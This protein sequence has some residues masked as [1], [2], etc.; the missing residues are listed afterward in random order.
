MRFTVE[1]SRLDVTGYF[2]SKISFT[3]ELSEPTR[4]AHAD[5]YLTPA[6]LTCDE[7]RTL[8]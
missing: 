1:F 5:F 7:E 4:V 3:L 6:S 8:D 2:A